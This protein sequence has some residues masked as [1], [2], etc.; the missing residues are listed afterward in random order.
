MAQHEFPQIYHFELISVFLPRLPIG[1]FLPSLGHL[2]LGLV[3]ADAVYSFRLMTPHFRFDSFRPLSHG[4]ISPW[5][6]HSISSSWLFS[7]RTS[8]AGVACFL[9]CASLLRLLLPTLMVRF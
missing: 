4:L 1:M 5:G 6:Y 7:P 8:L 2:E 3:P 9:A